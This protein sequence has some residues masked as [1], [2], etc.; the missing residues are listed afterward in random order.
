MEP[1]E[2]AAFVVTKCR[3]L[4]EATSSKSPAFCFFGVFFFSGCAGRE[5]A[6]TLTSTWTWVALLQNMHTCGNKG[7]E[8]NERMYITA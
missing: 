6:P 7:T 5:C 2:A 8:S 1:L 4:T 3:R